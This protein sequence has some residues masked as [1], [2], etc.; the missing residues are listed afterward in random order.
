MTG[1]RTRFIIIVVAMTTMMAIAAPVPSQSTTPAP[2]GDILFGARAKPR[3]DDPVITGN[4]GKDAVL[5]L[6]SEIGRTL[7]IDHY[8]SHFSSNW[9]NSRM[10]WDRAGGRLP[11]MNWAPEDPTYTW[12]QIAAGQADAI[13]DARASA[14]ATYGRRILLAFHHEPE[15]DTTTYGTPADYVAAWKHVVDRFRAAGATNVKFVLVLEAWTFQLDRADHWYPGRSYVDYVG[16]D[17]YNW[18]GARAG[19]AWRELGDIFTPFYDW[20]VAKGVPGMITETGCLEDP[21]NPDRKAQW[22]DNADLWLRSH[23]NIAAFLYFHSDR[24][25]RWWVD[26]S[27]ASLAA[28]QAMAHDPIFG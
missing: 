9:P 12:A 14:A 2:A 22:F 7:A 8:Y 19:A 6:E 24:M 3:A 1:A 26:T 11:L 20:T 23:P 13:I 25:W 5:H 21:N 4:K 28:Y 18:Y 27:A 16:A 17:G 15:N 10:A